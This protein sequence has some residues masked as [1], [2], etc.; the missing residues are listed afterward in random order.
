MWAWDTPSTFCTRASIEAKVL[1]LP[2]ELSQCKDIISCIVNIICVVYFYSLDIP[3][4]KEHTTNM[5]V[6]ITGGDPRPQVKLTIR[7]IPEPAFTKEQPE[8][9]GVFE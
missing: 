2:K 3:Y 7:V 5:P 6:G 4:I 8:L 1:L 9:A